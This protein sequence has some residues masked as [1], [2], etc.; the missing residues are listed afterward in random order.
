MNASMPRPVASTP[1]RERRG[2]RAGLFAAIC[3]G[4]VAM[5][6]ALLAARTEAPAPVTNTALQAILL[7]EAPQPEAPVT[8]DTTL[9]R[10]TAAPTAEPEIEFDLPIDPSPT[11]ITLAAPA[12]AP[13]TIEATDSPAAAAPGVESPLLVSSVEYLR[14]PVPRYPATAKQARL[15]GLV[16]LLVLVETD[17]SARDIRIE[18]SSGSPLL[19]RAAIDS[20]RAARFKPY[21][22][23]GVARQVVVVVPIE[24]SMRIRAA[25]R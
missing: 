22:V 18:R 9:A 7:T 2:V 16:Q 5:L 11:A 4:H 8:I 20:V 3:A 6:A 13:A 12:A 25:R 15:A 23:N 19:D 21:T 24:F 1:S 10:I 17:G 14:P